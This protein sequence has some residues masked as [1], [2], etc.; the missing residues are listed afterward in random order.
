MKKFIFVV[1]LLVKDYF[2]KPTSTAGILVVS[3]GGLRDVTRSQR[4]KLGANDRVT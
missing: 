4:K 1:K 2:I 3:G